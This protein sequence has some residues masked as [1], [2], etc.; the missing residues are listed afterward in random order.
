M[1]ERLNRSLLNMMS[2]FVADSAE[3]WDD[4]LPFAVQA[5][6]SS[7]HSSTGVTP[8]AM[9]Y[10]HEMRLPVDLMFPSPTS[11]PLPSC[12]PEYV[13]YLRKAL[14]GAHELAREHLARALVRQKRGYDA[15]AKSQAP[16]KV[17]ELVRYYYPVV[18]Q[19]N[20][21]A[22]PWIGP[23]KILEKVTEV[24]YRIAPVSGKGRTRVVHYDNLKP[25]IGD[26]DDVIEEPELPPVADVESEAVLDD[27]PDIMADYQD[28]ID[29]VTDAEEVAPERHLRPRRNIRKPVRFRNDRSSATVRRSITSRRKP[30][31]ISFSPGIGES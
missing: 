8:H 11:L 23:F 13:D 26:Y 29:P 20:K 14:G 30:A 22:R 28:Q 25:Y 24:D 5:Y 10:G 9:L 2:A 15:H 21:F 4:H 27:V 19:R 18:A 17:D 3:D 6:N 31:P 12:G 16:W 7:V 1:V